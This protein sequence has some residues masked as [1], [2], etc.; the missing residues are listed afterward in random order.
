MVYLSYAGI[1]IVPDGVLGPHVTSYFEEIWFIET[2]KA[3]ICDQLVDQCCWNEGAEP[4]FSEVGPGDHLHIVSLGPAISYRRIMNIGGTGKTSSRVWSWMWT[5]CSHAWTF[6]HPRKAVPRCLGRKN[7]PLSRF[8]RPFVITV[9]QVQ[10]AGR[11]LPLFSVGQGGE[12]GASLL[13]RRHGQRTGGWNHKG[14]NGLNHKEDN[15]G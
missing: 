8:T 5:A 4:G 7:L 13:R 2:L 15:G 3:S 10:Q 12:M 9:A 11:T 1:F 6:H 14:D